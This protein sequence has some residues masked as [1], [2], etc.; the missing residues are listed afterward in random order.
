MLDEPTTRELI[1]KF[2]VKI[3]DRLP[4]LLM[5]DYRIALAT[6]SL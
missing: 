4:F 3:N 2:L 5:N 1:S 6:N